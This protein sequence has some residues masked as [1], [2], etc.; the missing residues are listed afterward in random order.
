MQRIGMS[1]L[2][3]EDCAVELLC[4]HHVSALM[5]LEGDGETLGRIQPG[6][7]IGEKAFLWCEMWL[8]QRGE[9]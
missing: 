7:P 3:R 8:A 9:L 4:F 2:Y 5:V 6:C 1:R